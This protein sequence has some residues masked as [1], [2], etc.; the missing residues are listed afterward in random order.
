M[1]DNLRFSA[2]QTG[3]KQLHERW[4][5]DVLGHIVWHSIAIESRLLFFF[6]KLF[7]RIRIYFFPRTSRIRSGSRA[8][9]LHFQAFGSRSK[10]NFHSVL[11]NDSTLVGW[12]ALWLWAK[13]KCG[14]KS[15]GEEKWM[16][17]CSCDS[18]PSSSGSVFCHDG[19]RLILTHT[20][21]PDLNHSY[22]HW[23]DATFSHEPILLDFKHQSECRPDW[24]WQHDRSVT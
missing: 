10:N 17:C 4:A 11:P 15:R 18:A 19:L 21:K 13:E 9:M 5:A 6:F 12:F 23:E 16:S 3:P 7:S 2:S 24:L 14:K 22:W 20:R 1:V 8:G